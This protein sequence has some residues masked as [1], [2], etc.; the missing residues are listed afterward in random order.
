MVVSMFLSHYWST[1]LD[2]IYPP[3]CPLCGA[4]VEERGGWCPACLREAAVAGRLVLPE[5]SPVCAAWAAGLYRGG[6]RELIR[7]LKYHGKKANLPYIRTVLDTLP[8][9][10]LG[11][12]EAAF[13]DLAVP[14]PLHPDRE[15]QRGFNQ[16]ELIFR[17]WLDDCG[18]P[19]VRL[20]Q[21][22]RA[23]KPQFGLDRQQRRKNL[24]G[25]FALADLAEEELADFQGHQGHQGHRDRHPSG[26]RLLSGH[27]V[28]LV[29]DI[30]TTGT[31]LEACAE[32]LL[33]A[34]ARHVYALVLA[35]DHDRV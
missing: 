6:L 15:R 18:I 35:S 34:G 19:L 21:R 28:L 24:Q 20:L 23:T 32:V 12:A 14:V 13:I 1:L 16:T 5:G 25:A 3:R 9:E 7:G 17:D 31:T 2:F 4:Y 11:G 8:A 29:D 30:C 33:D 22:T 26:D 27:D 10:F